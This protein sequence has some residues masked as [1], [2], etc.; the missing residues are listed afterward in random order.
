MVGLLR[1]SV[2]LLMSSLRLSIL[3]CRRSSDWKRTVG[4]MPR[5]LPVFTSRVNSF[6]ISGSHFS[7]YCTTSV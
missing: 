5:S 3:S 2:L 1:Y 4:A 6:Q 7:R